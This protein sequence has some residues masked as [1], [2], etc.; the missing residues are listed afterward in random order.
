MNVYMSSLPIEI[1]NYIFTFSQGSTNKIMK[2]HFKDIEPY[3]DGISLDQHLI[4]ILITTQTLG[5][6]LFN[7]KTFKNA[8]YY[9]C[10]YCKSYI[11]FDNYN[12]YYFEHLRFCSENC[13]YIFDSNIML[14]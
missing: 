3:N 5:F 9:V 8:Y 1:I 13:E 10:D 2:T 7:K 4:Y 11:S 14:D 12:S 6:K